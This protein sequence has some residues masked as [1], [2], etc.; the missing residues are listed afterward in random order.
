MNWKKIINLGGSPD[1]GITIREKL[2]SLQDEERIDKSAI[3]GLEEILGEL[4]GLIA[5]VPRQRMGMRKVPIVRAVDLTSQVD[6]VVSTFTLPN[7]TV[8]VLGV[9]STQ[10]PVSF[11]QDVDWTFAGRTLTL[12]TSQVGIPQSGQTLWALCEVLFYG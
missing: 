11:R 4:R 2:E 10:F 5:A 12:V 6:G 9:F 1:T 3:K 8:K 7:D